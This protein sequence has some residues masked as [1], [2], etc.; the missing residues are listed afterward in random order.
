MNCR[1]RR[2]V[3]FV[4]DSFYSFDPLNSLWLFLVGEIRVNNSRGWGDGNRVV[5]I[6]NWRRGLFDLALL[7]ASSGGIPFNLSF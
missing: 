6:V 2:D 1:N 4:F 3:A 5:V 7:R